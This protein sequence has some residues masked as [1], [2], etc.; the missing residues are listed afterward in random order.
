MKFIDI[1]LDTLNLD[2]SALKR[3]ITKKT[4]AILAV[5]LLG[6]PND[7]LEMKKIIK[8]KNILLLEDNCE[9][10]AAKLA[11][12]FTGTYGLMGT[13]SS[14]F[15]HHI[16]TMEGGCVLTDNEELY[17]I[18]LSLREHG[19]TRNLPKNNFVTG[20]KPLYGQSHFCSVR[21]TFDF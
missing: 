19:W 20:K 12:K 21:E 17:Q 9:S 10:M 4:K 2:L 14:F 1:D 16:S 8:G 3:S 15:S 7:F 5:N 13:F 18:L 11:N 6:N